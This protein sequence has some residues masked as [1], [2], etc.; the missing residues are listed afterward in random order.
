MMR[1]ERKTIPAPD[2]GAGSFGGR[3]KFLLITLAMFLLAM[4][5]LYRGFLDPQTGKVQA[6]WIVGTLLGWALI[7]AVSLV[8]WERLF[9]G[10]RAAGQQ[11]IHREAVCK[12]GDFLLRE[13]GLLGI[14]VGC[15]VIFDIFSVGE[16]ALTPWYIVS[17]LIPLYI[18]V[19]TVF[20]LTNALPM[21]AT[22]TGVVSIVFAGVNY[23]VY[24]F[25]A[26]PIYPWDLFSVRTATVVV[27]D[28]Q[29]VA[30]IQLIAA[31]LFFVLMHQLVT[32]FPEKQKSEGKKRSYKPFF[33]RIGMNLAVIACLVLIYANAVFPKFSPNV[34]KM[35][36]NSA[37][38]GTVASFLSFLPWAVLEKPQGYSKQQAEMYLQQTGERKADQEKPQAVNIIMMMNES[39]SDYAV[40]D[41]DALPEDY[42]PF[43]HSLTENTVRGNLYVSCYGGNT[44]DTEF[45]TLTGN[46]ILYA[47]NT[48]FETQFSQ[49]MPSIVS[50]L[51]QQG[52]MVNAM[53]PMGEKDWNRDQVYDY[54]GF[55]TF[56]TIDD[57]P[58]DET[59]YLRNNYSDQA[60]VDW[61]IEQYEKQAGQKNGDASGRQE[62]NFIFNVTMQNHGG[63]GQETLNDRWNVSADLSSL[64]DYPE[65][66][67]FFSLMQETDRAIEKLITYFSSINEPTIICIY[68]DHQP[69]LR[70]GFIDVLYG[71]SSKKV[72]PKER[73]KKYTTPFVIWANY[74]IEEAYIPHMS[75]NYLGPMLL[76]YANADLD[77]YSTFLLD[78]FD[79]YPVVAST[80]MI[81]AEGI[82]YESPDEADSDEIRQYQ[83]LQY[84]RMKDAKVK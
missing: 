6:G 21:T 78:L 37:E 29:I 17:N 31:Y 28:Y 59:C 46:S 43:F 44:C 2:K 36:F 51:K 56:T 80:G 55:E 77:A 24:Q 72:S 16:Y 34:W 38:N 82:Y 13:I 4:P 64:G 65:A 39:M 5:W 15:L 83:K 49:P 54:L 58:Q 67:M 19:R 7:A 66:E 57:L 73:Q 8:K 40:F 74:D 50:T 33:V 41:T 3:K 53:H 84:Y 71:K 60:D 12:K 47:P 23:Y 10:R 76:A 32:F 30:C 52:Y 18:L 48:P 20:L 61:I 1:N 63:Y 62:K 45:E 70:D 42:L 11:D 35:M 27:E 75:A 22:L 69:D 9:A 25:R 68:G 81:D 14:S 79:K 26:R